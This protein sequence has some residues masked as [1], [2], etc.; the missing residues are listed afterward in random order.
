MG[1][2]NFIQRRT[3]HKTLILQKKRGRT[4]MGMTFFGQVHC[5]TLKYRFKLQS[6]G[7]IQ[8]YLG[9]NH[10]FRRLLI[11]CILL[12][13]ATQINFYAAASDS[14]ASM[15]DPIE[16][17]V[18]HCTKDERDSYGNS[19]EANKIELN[20][21]VQN[22]VLAF[23]V[24]TMVN[25]GIAFLQYPINRGWE[26]YFQRRAMRNKGILTMS[27][28]DLGKELVPLIKAIVN[29]MKLG[30]SDLLETLSSPSKLAS[31]LIE[32]YGKEEALNMAQNILTQLSDEGNESNFVSH[33]DPNTPTQD[34]QVEK[35]EGNATP[36]TELLN[37]RGAETMEIVEECNQFKDELGAMT[38]DLQS[39]LSMSRGSDSLAN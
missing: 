9:F 6:G 5:Q 13:G 3:L 18:S 38:Q 20:S 31:K 15:R 33:K 19:H 28:D 34:F 23:K 35:L 22:A 21:V 37:R 17:C 4:F 2:N 27:E 7:T 14:A 12:L 26:K 36:M 32:Q 16:R 8:K 39:S 30:G 11:A 10:C 29:D 24:L 1:E 25:A